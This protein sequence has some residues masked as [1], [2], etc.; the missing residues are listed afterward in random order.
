MEKS[1]NGVRVPLT[2]SEIVEFNQR[3]AEHEAL[4]AELAKT[5]YLRD[6]EAEY[7]TLNEKVE[8]LWIF[9]TSGDNAK[10]LELT[11][12]I[13]AVDAKYLAPQS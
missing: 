12:K 8:A 11:A 3:Q 7:P 2:E 9:A 4:M 6:R 13:E 1:I 10:I 5:Q